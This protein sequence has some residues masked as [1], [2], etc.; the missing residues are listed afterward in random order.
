[1]SDYQHAHH[2]LQDDEGDAPEF[3][4]QIIKFVEDYVLFIFLTGLSIFAAYTFMCP[5]KEEADDADTLPELSKEIPSYI[6]PSN[7]KLTDK[8]KP[9]K[10]TEIFN[11]WNTPTKFTSRHNTKAGVTGII[12]AVS[13]ELT[14]TIFANKNDVLEDQELVIKEGQC[15]ICNPQQWHKIFSHDPHMSFYVEFWKLEDTQ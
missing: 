2:G 10:T 4:V 7:W 8:H 5:V 3:I 11:R 1:M 13:G 15:A 14:V 9:Y 6:G 12:H